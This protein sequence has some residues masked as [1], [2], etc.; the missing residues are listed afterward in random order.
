VRNREKRR[1]LAARLGDLDSVE[2]RALEAT[3]GVAPRELPLHLRSYAL[4]RRNAACFSGPGVLPGEV[5]SGQIEYKLRLLDPTPTRFQ[6]LVSNC[7]P[8]AAACAGCSWKRMRTDGSAESGGCTSPPFSNVTLP[9]SADFHIRLGTGPCTFACL[10]AQVTQLNWRLSEG[11]GQCLYALGVE[12]NGHPRGLD[13]GDLRASLEVLQAMAAEVGAEAEVLQTPPGTADGRRCAVVRVTRAAAPALNYDDLRV[14]VA[15][16]VDSGKST[17]LGVL[18]H[19]AAGAPLLD[20]GRGRSRMRVF[21]HKHECESGHTSSISLQQCCYDAQ[22]GLQA[23]RVG[24][25]LP[26]AAPCNA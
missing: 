24:R 21:R 13:S 5:E 3:L 19:G 17:L 20:N 4:Q 8:R 2:A 15:G 22:G 12:D 14:A 6:Q 7:H 26:A 25:C 11:S 23:G 16:G 1:Q 18:S 10:P 9:Y